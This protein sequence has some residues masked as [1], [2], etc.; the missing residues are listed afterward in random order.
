[1]Q[2]QSNEVT[3]LLLDSSS[4]NK[5][6]LDQLMPIVYN[7]LHRLASGYLRG[8]RRD[9]TLEP[10]ALIHEAY[11]RL[12]DDTLP[13]WQSRAHFFG[14]AARAMRQI[15]VGHARRH[16][17]LKPGGD[18]Q[19]VPL[20][21]AMSYSHERPA[22]VVALDEALTALAQLDERKARLVELRYIGGLSV[23][24]A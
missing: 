2:P 24:E 12:V 21:E 10:T 22:A 15:L 14:V 4:G 18:E 9:H 8:E 5:A 20:D 16:H 7:E 13:Q 1:M 6:A 3:R 19:K 23:E 17:A 11:Q